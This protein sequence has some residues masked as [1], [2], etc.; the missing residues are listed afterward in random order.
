MFIEIKDIAADGGHVVKFYEHDAELVEA[1]VPYLAEA[2][3]A[4]EAAVVIAT[5]AHRDAFASALRARGLDPERATADGR[6]LLLDAADTMSRFLSD[7]NI[8]PGAF[9]EVIGDLIRSLA[10]SGRAVRAYGEMVALLWDAGDVLTAIELEMQWNDLARELPFSLFCSYPATS[11]AGAQHATALH[12]VCHLHSSVLSPWAHDE[13]PGASAACAQTGISAA[14]PAEP[15][16]PGRARRLVVDALRRWGRQ[17]TLVNDVALVVSELASNAVRHA[18]SAFSV[19]VR[20]RGGSLH[21]AVQDGAALETTRS[22]GG[23]APQP[24]HGLGLIDALATQWGVDGTHDGKVVWAELPYDASH[25]PL[26]T[27]AQA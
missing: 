11:V 14:F 3:R 8:D 15:D 22:D 16:S 10:A 12:H 24:L 21:I 17:E 4:D 2:I 7:G 1:V 23:L 13:A 5:E 18:S 6:L 26:E 25:A 19:T 27:P 9:N 20:A